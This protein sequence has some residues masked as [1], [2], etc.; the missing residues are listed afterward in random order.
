EPHPLTKDEVAD[1]AGACVALLETKGQSVEFTLSEMSV[2]GGG[3]LLPADAVRVRE[4][5]N[6]LLA[7]G[8][9]SGA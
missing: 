9:V 8:D 7:T 6:S 3:F 4:R 5:V 1:L 2:E